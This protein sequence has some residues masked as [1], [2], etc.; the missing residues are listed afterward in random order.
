MSYAPP[1]GWGIAKWMV[2]VDPL[3]IEKPKFDDFFG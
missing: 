3:V 2:D 1:S